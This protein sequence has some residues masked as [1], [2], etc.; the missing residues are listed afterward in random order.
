LVK[1]LSISYNKKHFAV[2]IEEGKNGGIFII[3]G[4]GRVISSVPNVSSFAFFTG[5]TIRLALNMENR[6]IFFSAL[7]K[8]S[9]HCIDFNGHIVSMY[10]AKPSQTLGLWVKVPEVLYL[11][12]KHHLTCTCAI[13]SFSAQDISTNT[14]HIFIFFILV[15]YS[16]K[17]Y[18]VLVKI[19]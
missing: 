11:S 7:C 4:Y 17:I 14:Q 18:C 5:N 3:N 16:I 6:R 12:Q 8:K 13:R 19:S 9:V 1:T 15:K 2:E 10:G